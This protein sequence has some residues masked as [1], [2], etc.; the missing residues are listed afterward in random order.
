MYKVF[1]NNKPII[2]SDK[3]AVD[4][5]C[6]IYLYK[7]ISFNEVL[8]K[9]RHTQTS[10]IYLYHTDLIFLW[11]EFK[12]F[13][14]TV[15]AAGGMV[16]KDHKEILLIFRNQ[17]WDLPKGKM[18]KDESREETAIREVEEECGITK[19]SIQKTL[20]TT[21]HIF[22]EANKNKLKITYWFLMKTTD[23]KDPVPQQEEGITLAEFIPLSNITSIYDSMYSNIKNLIQKQI[24]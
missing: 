19:L 22:Y 16:F 15:N 18:E 7:E 6:E 10:G 8:H 3:P 1:V 13:F 21:Y 14:T 23:D 4:S 17:N 5:N 12:A 20:Q 11:N 24:Q 9:L 2:L